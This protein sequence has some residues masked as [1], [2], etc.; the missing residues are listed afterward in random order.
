MKN[1]RWALHAADF[2]KAVELIKRQ[3]LHVRHDPKRSGKST[4]EHQTRGL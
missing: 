2:N 3:E 1:H 4:D